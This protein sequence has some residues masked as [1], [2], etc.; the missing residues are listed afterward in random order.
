V[1]RN[2]LSKV[3]E[4][5]NSFYTRL[6]PHHD[7]WELWIKGNKTQVET[8][9]V[10]IGTIL[11]QNTNWTNVDK[12][13]TNLKEAQILSF[14][15]LLSLNQ[16][17]I[18]EIIRPAGFYKQKALYLISLAELLLKAKEIPSRAELLECKGV[19][20]E[21]ADSI[22]LYC[23]QKPLA[24]VGTYTRRFLARYHGKINYLSCKYEN[25]QNEIQNDFK[26]DFEVLGRFHA[27]IVCH[28]QNICQKNK[29]K[30][31]ECLL[32]NKCIYNNQSQTDPNIADIQRKIMYT[33]KKSQ[34]KHLDRKVNIKYSRG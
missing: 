23:F 31:P 16:D 27:L 29:P 32:R 21:T 13:I 30:C 12:S 7:T 25:I 19:G 4:V 15:D 3:Y 2:L 28:C 17:E 24:I 9:E 6:E 18:R 34:N 8:F 11:V 5:L 26:D 22:L 33:P 10:A 14:S 20:K 1:L